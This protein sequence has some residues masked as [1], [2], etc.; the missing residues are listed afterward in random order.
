MPQPEQLMKVI[1]L[2]CLGLACLASLLAF[3]FDYPAPLK[4]LARL[5]CVMLG[6]ELIAN[7]FPVTTDNTWLYNAFNIF[8]YLILVNIYR[9]ISSH[10]QIKNSIRIFN[11]VFIFFA[12]CN[13]IFLQRIL[14]SQKY[15][16][17][18]LI[19]GGGA[20]LVFA[21]LY[22]VE[23]I[24]SEDRQA[25]SRNPYFWLSISLIIFVGGTVPFLGMLNYLDSNFPAFTSIYF[26]YV[27]RAATIL[28]NLGVTLTFLCKTPY[29]KFS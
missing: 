28:L 23:L 11:F 29:L 7:F 15:Q 14:E 10:E 6:I 1:A 21:C 25:P 4:T 17:Y 5:W 24:M 8:F 22:L 20:L 9:Q 26:I 12:F 19:L 3:R 2:L 18:T 13:S 16:T 27:C